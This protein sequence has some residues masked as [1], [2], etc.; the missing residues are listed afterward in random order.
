MTNFAIGIPTLN[1][2]DLLIPALLYY[3]QDFPQT[4]IYVLDNGNQTELLNLN[5]PNLVIKR[6]EK[7][8]GVAAS[9]NELCKEIFATHEYA[10]IMNDDVYWGRKEYEVANVIRDY[11]K[12]LYTNP[13]DW[14]IFIICRKTF[15]RIGEFDEGF[16]PAYFEDN[17]YLYRLKLSGISE[18]K[19]PFL[20]PIIHRKSS[21]MEKDITIHEQ[22]HKCKERYIQKWGGE[23]NQEKFKTPFNKT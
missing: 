12:W 17:D 6:K 14:S 15:D 5:F 9:W 8:I 21:T 7:N 18:F 2:A 3:Q 11:D 10:V 20:L 16:Y 4:K 13:I 19:I 22:F 23:P 1:R